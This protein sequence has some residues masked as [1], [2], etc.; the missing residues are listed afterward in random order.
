MK[1]RII[2]TALIL[3]IVMALSV[4]SMPGAEERHKFEIPQ[5]A[6]K[7]SDDLYDL[8]RVNFKGEE[9]QGYAFIHH[10]KE[11]ARNSGGSSA[12]S[13]CFSYLAAGAKWKTTE[14]YVLDTFNNDGM[15]DIFVADVVAASLGTWDVQVPFQIFG[16]RDNLGVVD[17]ADANAPDGKNEVLFGSIADPGTIAV[18]TVWGIFGGPTRQRRIVEFDAVFDDDGTFKWGDATVN[19]TLMDLQD[20]AAHE[21]GHAAGMGHPSNSCTEETMYAYASEGEIKKRDLN[22]GDITGIKNLYK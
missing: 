11:F 19:N 13:N 15:S 17:G 3:L 4:I 22:S 5:H 2:P 18:T 1:D 9:L 6:V 10:K 21:L 8:G 16:P 12:A 20:I 7:V 14:S